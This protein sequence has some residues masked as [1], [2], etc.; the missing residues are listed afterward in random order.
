MSQNFHIEFAQI[1]ITTTA[2]K[3]FLPKLNEIWFEM[4]EEDSSLSSFSFA[5]KPDIKSR[6]TEVFIS[7]FRAAEAHFLPKERKREV[8]S[9]SRSGSHC[10]FLKKQEFSFFISY[11]I[12]TS[13]GWVEKTIC[14]HNILQK[15]KKYCLFP[16]YICLKR[17]KFAGLIVYNK[18]AF[19]VDIYK[20]N[21]KR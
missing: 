5:Q 16:H 20:H 17:L 21:K 14:L 2:R 9:I 3:L 10:F 11:L 18:V 8:P 12:G 4:Y 13:S 15:C 6:K 7:V 19:I 1:A